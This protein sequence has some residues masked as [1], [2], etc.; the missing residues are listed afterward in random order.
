[1]VIG[2]NRYA[3]S[4]SLPVNNNLNNTMSMGED[5]PVEKVGTCIVITL[6][7]GENRVNNSFIS[8]MHRALDKAERRVV[9][10]NLH[11]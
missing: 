7:R 11:L 1:L 8:A 9:R 4:K 3:F 2:K 6:N 10:C 5:F